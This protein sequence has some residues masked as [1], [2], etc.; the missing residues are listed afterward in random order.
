MFYAFDMLEIALNSDYVRSTGDPEPFLQ[1]MA[2]AGFTAVH[3]CHQWLGEHR[4]R[5][6]E[7]RRIAGLLKSCGLRMTDLH[8]VV[9]LFSDWTSGSELRRRAGVGLINNRIEMTADLGGDAVVLHLPEGRLR[10]SK[11]LKAVRK[12]L[13]ELEPAS[14]DA[15]VRIALENLPTPG[16]MEL[17]VK[18]FGEYPPEYLGLCYDSGHGNMVGNG[19]ELL[20]TL[21]AGEPNGGPAESRAEHR[22]QGRTVSRLA[23]M[24][25]HDNHGERDLHLPPF[26]G[27]I[28]WERLMRVIARAYQGGYSKPLCL[29]CSIRHSSF[30]RS[31]WGESEF[32]RE[33]LQAGRRIEELKELACGAD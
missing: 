26:R 6:K 2:E 4:Y 3:W 11:L 23:A 1:R 7:I 19:I 24:H 8:G 20:E 16:H 30:E 12:S 31:R 9:G 15:G 5:P 22:H 32:L 13:D 21:L 29:E 10:D 28:D 14:R 17:L 27:S 18:L 25:L 33:S